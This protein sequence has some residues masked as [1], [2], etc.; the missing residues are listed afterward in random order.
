MMDNWY[1]CIVLFLRFHLVRVRKEGIP[2]WG[3]TENGKEFKENKIVYFFY[4]Q[5]VSISSH[6]WSIAKGNKGKPNGVGRK[7]RNALPW[8]LIMWVKV[9]TVMSPLSFSSVQ[10]L[11]RVWLFVTPLT[12][13]S[14]ASLSIT[15][16]RSSPKPMSIESVKPSNHLILCLPLL[17]L[18]SIFPSIRVFSNESALRIRW[19]KYWNFRFSI[20][21]S[22]EYSGLISFR[23]DW[24]DF[25][26]FFKHAKWKNIW[27]KIESNSNRYL[28]DLAMLIDFILFFFFKCAWFLDT[29]F[30]EFVTKLLLFYFIA[31]VLFFSGGGAAEACGILSLWSGIELSPSVLEGEVLTFRPQQ[32]V[33]V[34][35]TL[36]LRWDYFRLKS[37][38]YLL[39]EKTK[40]KKK[41]S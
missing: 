30:S 9:H 39:K 12:A 6:W 36:N 8:D 4:I 23:M 18:P 1:R 15:N 31:S 41:K 26:T 40:K 16:S 20:S 38:G 3:A 19:P 21:P 14:Q 33:P 24:L 32:K 34:N 35:F 7:E 29:V 22:N 27:N 11:S 5:G 2:I 17:L 10:S 28:C 37:L 13:V 25:L